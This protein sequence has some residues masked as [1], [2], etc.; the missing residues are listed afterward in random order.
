MNCGRQAF[1]EQ[2]RHG[3]RANP[4]RRSRWAVVAEGIR[5]SGGSGES[6]LGAGPDCLIP[7]SNQG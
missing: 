3:L 4:P 1:E 6:L 7:I 2:K 5:V